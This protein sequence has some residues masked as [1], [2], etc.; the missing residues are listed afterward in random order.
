MRKASGQVAV[1]VTVLLIIGLAAYVFRERFGMLPRQRIPHYYSSVEKARPIPTTL[2]PTAFQDAR[3]ARGYAIAKR[4]PEV[5]V[6]QPSYCLLMQRHHHSLLACFVTDDAQHCQTCVKEAYL[7][8][9]LDRAGK[10]ATEIRASII[11][12]EW[13]KIK[14]EGPAPQQ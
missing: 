2:P 13:R 7:A 12:G 6:Q 8:D 5:L 14:L 9:E 11:A 4:I 3:V 1:S 10:T